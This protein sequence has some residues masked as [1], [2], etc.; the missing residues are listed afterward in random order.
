MIIELRQANDILQRKDDD[1]KRNIT[2]YETSIKMLQSELN[3]ALIDVEALRDKGTK[4]DDLYRDF[5]RLEKEKIVLEN[6]LTF[7]SGISDVKHE[8]PINEND[9]KAK[10]SIL[11]TDKE[12]LTRENLRLVEANKKLEDKID[13]LE[14]ELEE[15]KK[16]SKDYLTQ[17]F[18]S[19]NNMF[20]DYEK[21]INQELADLR[22]KHKEELESAK[23]NLRDIYERQISFLKD[24]KEELET[25]IDQL[26]TQNKEK[27]QAFE[28]ILEE[29]RT[30][31]RRVNHDLSEIRIQLR[32]KTDDLDRTQALYEEAQANYKNM[33]MEN[34]MLKDKNTVLKGEYYKLEASIK[35]ETAGL[36]AQ[37]AVAKEQLANYENIENE[38]DEA[39]TGVGRS[40]MDLDNTNIYLQ[41][42]HT[43]PTTSKRRIQQALALAQRLT[44]KQKECG[45]LQKRV[46]Q[47]E[48]DNENLQ[49]EANL[50]KTLLGKSSQPY[51]YLIQTIEE[52]EREVK[53]LKDKLRSTQDEYQ[54]LKAENAHLIEVN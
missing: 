51:G 36:R 8:A 30:L 13:R 12:Y 46:S 16:M 32:I 48:K 6:K 1:V 22:G 52:K 2:N 31:Q 26:T 18:N 27:S 23:N 10:Y 17:L 34:E 49:G 54:S 4:Y 33:K 39:I 21:K 40:G 5:V 45:D 14:A 41:T 9:I 20:Y 24:N 28:E 25:K 53:E 29:N 19:K 43:A 11:C 50:S 15:T 3:K 35:E 42:I 47:L 44:I 38:I 37:L 7:F